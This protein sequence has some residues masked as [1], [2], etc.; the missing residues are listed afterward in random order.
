MKKMFNL[1]VAIVAMSSALSLASCDK[2]FGNSGNDQTDEG[3]KI[4]EGVVEGVLE[5]A[6]SNDSLSNDTT[7]A[8]TKQAPEANTSNTDKAPAADADKPAAPADKK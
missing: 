8:T 3:N 1:A 4:V 5:G 2:L 6:L 7:G